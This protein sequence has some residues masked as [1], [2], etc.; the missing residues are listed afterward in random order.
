MPM[1]VYGRHGRYNRLATAFEKTGNEED[2]WFSSDD[3]NQGKPVSDDTTKL[4]LSQERCT[5]LAE[6]AIEPNRKR[7]ANR[8]QTD[9]VWEFLER[10]ASGQKRRRRATCDATEREDSASQEFINAVNVVQGIVSSLKPAKEVVEH[11]AELEAEVQDDRG[12]NGQAVY[13]KTRTMLAK[14]EEE[15]DA[16]PVAQETEERSAPGDE[17]L[18]RHFNELRTMGETLKYSEDLDFILT[19]ESMT[20]GEQRRNNMM[21]LCLD[22]MNNEDLCQYIVKYRHREV[23]EWC[24]QGT[25]PKQKVIS[26]LQCFIADKIP[27]LRHDKRWSML[28]LEKF[29]LPLA[30]DEVFPKKIAGSRLVK[31]NYQDLLRR[32]KFTNTCQYALYIW[33]TYML[34]RDAVGG[35]V[36]ALAQLI[37]RG[38]FE[39]WDTACSLLENNI[40]AA[41]TGSDIEEYAHAFQALARLSKERLANEGVLKCLIKLTNH[42][43]VLAFSADLLPKLVQNLA[44]SVRLHQEK[45]LGSI[46]EAIANLLILQLGLCLNIVSETAA[47]ASTDEITDFR[48][49]F[50]SVLANKPTEMSFVLQ[51]FLLVYAYSAGAAGVQLTPAEAEFLKSELEAFAIDVS[52]YNRNIHG[53]ITRVLQTL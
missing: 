2:S 9:P 25:D 6:G 49:V 43:T 40:I 29:I 5:E 15:S 53:R 31:L 12:K 37:S 47:T 13:G 36:L 39:D 30:T 19:D 7:P 4:S 35:A 18:S 22:M 50:D 21:R 32:L 44:A 51:L 42:S 8:T 24:F 10:P 45:L 20:T 33:A 41:P 27:L 17:V 38:R 14:A 23:W 11:W 1:K 26:L 48:T 46:S 16:E 52:S 3:E 34:D 28:S